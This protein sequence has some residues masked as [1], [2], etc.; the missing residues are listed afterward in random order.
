MT[1]KHKRMNNSILCK[2]HDESDGVNICFPKKEGDCG[3]D[4]IISKDTVVPPRQSY[5]TD[6][7]CGVS[8]KIPDGYFG[9]I[10]NRS[11]TSRKLGLWVVPGVIDCGY[12]GELFACVYNMTPEEIKVG[13]GT[14]ISQCIFLPI[15][16]FPLCETNELPSTERGTSG[17]GSSGL[18]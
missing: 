4:L 13:K 16:T 1:S 17:F 6:V 2:K 10:I 7:P 15:N 18:K 8:I 14:R 3:Y 9:L 12:T 11:S 5:P